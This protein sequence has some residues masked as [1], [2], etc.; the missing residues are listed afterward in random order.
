MQLGLGV[1]HQHLVGG[2]CC[3]PAADVERVL[4]GGLFCSGVCM[5]NNPVAGCLVETRALDE[6]ALEGVSIILGGVRLRLLGIT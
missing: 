1:V 5:E 3:G 4:C 2:G 6:L